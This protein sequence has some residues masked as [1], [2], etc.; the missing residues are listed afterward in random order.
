MY[1]S[2]LPPVNLFITTPPDLTLWGLYFSTQGLLSFDIVHTLDSFLHIHMSEM[3]L[4]QSCQW[5]ILLSIMLPNSIQVSMNCMILFFSSWLH[6]IP[7][8]LC[9]AISLT[10]HLSL[11]F[12]M[13]PYLICC[14][15]NF[16]EQS[17]YISFQ[18]STFGLGC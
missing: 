9:I 5:L 1:V 6:N 3:I 18:I 8:C 11:V 10:I 13:F 17:V 4:Y 7:W 16:R 14:T 12:G 2:I 15:T